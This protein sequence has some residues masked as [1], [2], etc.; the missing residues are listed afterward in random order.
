M[1]KAL[2]LP[3][4]CHQFLAIVIWFVACGYFVIL[5]LKSLEFMFLEPC[6]SLKTKVGLEMSGILLETF[7]SKQVLYVFPQY[8]RY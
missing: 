7:S 1:R 6:K 5:D 3:D 4:F 2:D 8:Y